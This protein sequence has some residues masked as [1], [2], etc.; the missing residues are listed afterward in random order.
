MKK[1]HPMMV[2][3]IL[4]VALTGCMG[5]DGEDVD[6]SS[7]PPDAEIEKGLSLSPRNYTEEGFS[8]F[9]QRVE[10][11]C[12]YATWAGD[13]TELK[14]PNSAPYVLIDLSDTYGYI[15]IILV[16]TPLDDGE[17]SSGT[18]MDY[19]NTINDFVESED[20][21]FISIG[22]EVNSLYKTHPQAYSMLVDT[23][24]SAAQSIKEVSPDTNVI[25]TFQL[26]R[27]KGL[28]GGLFG[29]NSEDGTP[30]WDLIDD[31]SLADI[32][33]FTTYPCL[34]ERD[35]SD[36]PV[37]YYLEILSHTSKDIAIVESGWFRTGPEGWESSSEEQA[38][39]LDIL[40]SSM[41]AISPRFVVW[42]FLYDQQVQYP[43]DTMGLL[44]EDQNTSMVWSTWLEYN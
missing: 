44:A 21:P 11:S 34:V 9:F 39:F 41:D 17:A 15:P 3:L 22:V 43:F 6:T 18:I 28:E 19:I 1:I 26:E 14:V 38:E 10:L 8:D 5:Q 31:F 13:W 40:L 20:I 42:S 25:V 29:G 33:A 37:D 23:F 7:P 4:V 2:V 24:S 32:I 35:P 12:D 27:M 16:S 36:I 30:Q